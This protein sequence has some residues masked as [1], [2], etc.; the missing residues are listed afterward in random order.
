MKSAHRVSFRSQWLQH[1]HEDC[2]TQR[3]VGKASRSLGCRTWWQMPLPAKLSCRLL[4]VLV[5]TKSGI[6]IFISN[7][8]VLSSSTVMTS[9]FP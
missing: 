7:S 1:Q 9:C 4:V 3:V 5:R 6:R 8:Y 2:Q